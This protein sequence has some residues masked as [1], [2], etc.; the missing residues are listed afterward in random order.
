MD[1]ILVV[2]VEVFYCADYNGRL[3]TMQV[4]DM[5]KEETYMP[6]GR[7]RGGAGKQGG[8]EEEWGGGCVGYWIGGG[9]F[10]L[11]PVPSQKMLGV[12]NYGRLMINF[13]RSTPHFLPRL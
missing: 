9:G 8:R 10:P 6:R 3:F 7:G 1:T 4:I 12:Y 13:V 2:T 5:V 11:H